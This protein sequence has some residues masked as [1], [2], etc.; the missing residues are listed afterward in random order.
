MSVAYGALG[1][2]RDTH[3][4]DSL[5]LLSAWECKLHQLI[6]ALLAYAMFDERTVTPTERFFVLLAGIEAFYPCCSGC[7]WLPIHIGASS[8]SNEEVG[9]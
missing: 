3:E 9:R 8:K 1:F 7:L 2:M 4:S 6:S 5:A